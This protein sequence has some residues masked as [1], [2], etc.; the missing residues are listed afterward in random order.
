MPHIPM[1]DRGPFWDTQEDIYNTGFSVG[2][3]VMY[4][5][6]AGLEFGPFTVQGFVIPSDNQYGEEGM[7]FLDWDC[8]WFPVRAEKLMLL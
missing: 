5:N 3:R 2:D 6:P 1:K 4:T 8:P 7:L